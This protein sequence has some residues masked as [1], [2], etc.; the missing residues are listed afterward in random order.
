[1]RAM[2]V[3]RTLAGL[4][5]AAGLLNGEMRISAGDAVKAATRKPK[6]E[7]SPMARQMRIEGDVEV[8]VHI[9]NAGDVDHVKPLSG[10]PML[11]GAVVRTVKDWK[12]SPFTADGKPVPAVTAL[13]FSFKL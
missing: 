11:T 12:F 5:L 1:M 2:N 6:P 8:E 10:N 4:A 9:N 13:R 3:L 7:Y